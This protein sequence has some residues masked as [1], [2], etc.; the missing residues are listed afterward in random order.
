MEPA[1]ILTSPPPPNFIA[2]EEDEP[3]PDT[4]HTPETV[5]DWKQALK[6]KRE[7]TL[8][9]KQAEQQ[10]ANQ[11]QFFSFSASSSARSGTPTSDSNPSLSSH[12]PV[13]EQEDETNEWLRNQQVLGYIPPPPPR[14][15]QTD[16]PN[17]MIVADEARKKIKDGALKVLENAKNFIKVASDT[18][19]N[20]AESVVGQFPSTPIENKV[21]NWTHLLTPDI[22]PRTG[23]ERP[24]QT[25][26]DEDG[27]QVYDPE[28]LDKDAQ[29]MSTNNSSPVSS[30]ADGKRVRVLEPE[31][32]DEYVEV[33]DNLIP[34]ELLEEDIK[35]RK[36]LVET[37]KEIQEAIKA[38]EELEKAGQPSQS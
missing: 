2:H 6:L 17:P 23:A 20:A 19:S 31:S 18:V 7:L 28:S 22:P 11:Q 8:K 32:E 3:Y 38:V 35:A 13:W 30:K 37:E 14:P 4:S 15:Q 25:M 12:P 26:V 21:M 27:W 34:K 24:I 16:F 36:Q 1:N 5:S 29:N 9:T 10:W 33:D